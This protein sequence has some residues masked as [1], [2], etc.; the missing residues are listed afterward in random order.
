MIGFSLLPSILGSAFHADPGVQLKAN[1][2]L[3]QRLGPTP[4]LRPSFLF[5]FLLSPSPS[6]SILP[7]AEEAGNSLGL[8][9]Q[10]RLLL[11]ESQQVGATGQTS[12]SAPPP[13]SDGPL[14]TGLFLRL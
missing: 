12:L 14:L 1:S 7:R 4:L 6:L 13:A 10:F 9:T 8:Q 2:S 11:C 5:L 3:G